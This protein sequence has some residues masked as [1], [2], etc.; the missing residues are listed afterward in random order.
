MCTAT[1]LRKRKLLSQV[2]LTSAT[3]NRRRRRWQDRRPRQFWVR[4]GR[5]SAWW[6]N[7]MDN[8]T[9]ASEWK[10]NFRM[11]R[12]T[13]MELCEDLR[14]LLRRKSTRMRRAISVETQ[15]AVTLYYLSD[16]GRYR[17]VANAFGISRSSVSIIVR[18]VCTA[19][20]EYL[21]PIYV[22]L[23]TSEREVQELVNQFHVFDGFPQC[24]GAVDGTH[25]PIKEPTENASD[26][27]NRKGYTS[28]NV[29]ATC[30]YNYRFIDVVVKW[31]GSVHDARIFKNSTLNFKLRDG[32][33]PTCHKTIVEGEDAVPVCI[34]GDPAYPLLPYLM[35][36]F[37]N[38][39]STSTE[40]FFGYRMSSSRMVIE[41][42]FGRLKGRWGALRRAMD[43]SLDDLPNV[44]FA[45][46]V[47]H[48]YCEV[49]GET[50]S[51]EKLKESCSYEREFQPPTCTPGYGAAFNETSGK[52]IR[53]IFAKF[54]D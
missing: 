16:E 47:L 48:N 35:K 53:Q 23:P 34:L 5:A 33:I 39:G 11:S 6:D 1:F 9:V 20:S 30:D 52:H 40:Q 29:Q 31:P 15:M 18:R 27:I 37:A 24:M 41:C 7:M 12:P 38:G 21:G 25:I 26:Y 10:E 42:A 8:V 14:P 51:E 2:S 17:K 32:S 54:F 50:L 36:E 3:L 22:H 46:F 28:I 49:H 44:I 43:I 45:C 13:F 4:P 19:I